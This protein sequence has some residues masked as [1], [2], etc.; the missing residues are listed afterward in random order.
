MNW[1]I[2][3]NLPLWLIFVVNIGAVHR[4]SRIIA[5]DTITEPVRA[6]VTAKWH[7]MLVNLML[8]M[9]CL[10][11]WFAIIAVALTAW[12]TTRNWWLV[13]AS[14]LTAADIAG[15]MSERA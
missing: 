5:R 8:C 6:R 2:W 7:G 11:F 10:T 4:L 3:Y 1:D 15:F 12:H 13:I 9:W 14:I